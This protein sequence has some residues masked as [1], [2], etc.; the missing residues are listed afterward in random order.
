MGNHR[1]PD[2]ASLAIRPELRDSD[3]QV[4]SAGAEQRHGGS[5][6]FEEGLSE[7][8]G[9]FTHGLDRTDE[10]AEP[11][12]VGSADEAD[13]V[14]RID[15]QPVEDRRQVFGDVSALAFDHGPTGPVDQLQIIA[16]FVGNGAFEVIGRV[17]GCRV[18]S[19]PAISPPAIPGW[20][21]RR[22]RSTRRSA[23]PAPGVAAARGWC[24]WA[25]VRRFHL[26]PP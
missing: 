25:V 1:V 7:P 15:V 16:D 3:W 21:P 24:S 18:I 11:A 9:Q 2:A 13:V 10:V 8:V 22:S 6:A 14:R 20:D 26:Q 12:F 17:Y 4:T 19:P 5:L 23:A